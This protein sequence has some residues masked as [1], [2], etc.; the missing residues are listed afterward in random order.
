VEQLESKLA[1]QGQMK[2]LLAKV[3]SL[4]S[5]LADSNAS[6]DEI[7]GGEVRNLK[8]QVAET[9]FKFEEEREEHDKTTSDLKTVKQELKDVKAERSAAKQAVIGLTA[10]VESLQ[11]S[12]NSLL[13][14]LKIAKDEKLSLQSDKEMLQAQLA[15]AQSDLKHRNGKQAPVIKKE[16]S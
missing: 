13:A 16:R 2:S 12:E 7:I 6:Q 4:E 5:Q 15:K 9:T 8:I 14:E 10:Q 3:K 11:S 1:N